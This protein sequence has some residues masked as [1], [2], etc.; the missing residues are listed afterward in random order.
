MNYDRN[1]EGG[2]HRREIRENGRVGVPQGLGCAPTGFGR[3]A[4]GRQ[5]H[6]RV[7]DGIVC[8]KAGAAPHQ[9]DGRTSR[10]RCLRR[11]ATRSV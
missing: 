2:A 1:A 7:D 9:I 11:E 10:G 3:P 4:M 6:V 8:P 5:A